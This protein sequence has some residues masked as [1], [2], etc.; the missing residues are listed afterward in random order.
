MDSRIK[1]ATLALALVLSA[2]LIAVSAS[3]DAEA[4]D[5]VPATGDLTLQ[6]DMGG[7][8]AHTFEAGDTLTI[9]NQFSIENFEFVFEEGSVISIMDM[10][11]EIVGSV[12]ISSDGALSVNIG[13]TISITSGTLD[14]TADTQSMSIS[15]LDVTGSLSNGMQLQAG[16]ASI[17][18]D[19]GTSTT[20]ASDIHMTFGYTIS[21]S[22]EGSIQAFLDGPHI[23]IGGVEVRDGTTTILSA[24][25]ISLDIEM[26]QATTT[27]TAIVSA[28]VG[29]LQIGGTTGSISVRDVSAEFNLSAEG[30]MSGITTGTFVGS[31][32]IDARV[33]VGDFEYD[34]ISGNETSSLN[35]NDIE[36]SGS[37]DADVSETSIT[38]T[39][40]GATSIR[41]GGATFDS[42]QGKMELSNANL[43]VSVTMTSPMQSTQPVLTAQT[44]SLKASVDGTISSFYFN[45]DGGSIT[46][47]DVELDIGLD[48]DSAQSTS[49]SIG[50]RI[51][52][53]DNTDGEGTKWMM[54]NFI[55]DIDNNTVSA[56]RGI[57]TLANG[58]NEYYTQVHEDPQTGEFT[59]TPSDP[60]EIDADGGGD[61]NT[62]LYIAIVVVVIVI[63]AVI[64]VMV[65]RRKK[66]V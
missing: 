38:L 65:S 36:A 25:A 31:M 63:I 16:I 60:F 21:Q 43:S 27:Q 1:L 32:H 10:P 47:R 14:I 62:I 40:D 22:S 17:S 66:S 41:V 20:V 52:Q 13:E 19:S 30:D 51:F 64:A 48:S 35:I 55:A 26:N 7:I 39:S 3:D 2:S 28:S 53:S 18:I 8:G 23:N 37:F 50:A 5:G 49:G 11:Q 56:D 29:S 46:M 33:A 12:T 58:T 42:T 6:G 54:E 34:V 15:G 45:T 9:T 24:S 57:K 61:D 44:N 4:A 59:G